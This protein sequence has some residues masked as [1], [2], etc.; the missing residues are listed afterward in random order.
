MQRFH[1][2]Y[3]KKYGK[4]NNES[5]VVLKGKTTATYQEK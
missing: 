1:I 5:E 4:I 3:A 2:G